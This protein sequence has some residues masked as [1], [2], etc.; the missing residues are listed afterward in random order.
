MSL[1]V[2]SECK[3]Q[4]CYESQ[5]RQ[6]KNEG[7]KIFPCFVRTDRCYAPLVLWTLCNWR[8]NLVTKDALLRTP[9]WVARSTCGVGTWQIMFCIG[10]THLYTL[11]SPAHIATAQKWIHTALHT[12]YVPPP[13]NIPKSAP[14]FVAFLTTPNSEKKVGREPLCRILV[15]F[16]IKSTLQPYLIWSSQQC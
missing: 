3:A 8:H 10:P 16:L 5:S 15:C 6:L 13:F 4:R 1:P 9:F 2:S 12:S 7:E 11:P 14:V